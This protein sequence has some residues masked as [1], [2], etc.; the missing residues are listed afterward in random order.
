MARCPKQLGGALAR[1]VTIAL[2]LVT[3]L[4]RTPTTTSGPSLGAIAREM[5]RLAAVIAVATAAASKSATSGSRFGAIARE[6]AGLAAVIA[7]AAAAA[8]TTAASHGAISRDVSLFVAIV[9]SHGPTTTAPAL[10]RLRTISGQMSRLSA[11]V[12][13][14]ISHVDEILVLRMITRR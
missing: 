10:A 2:A 8:A 12:A 7:V 9:A 5:A 11:I 3:L 6:M 4:G 14:A 13:R 1:D